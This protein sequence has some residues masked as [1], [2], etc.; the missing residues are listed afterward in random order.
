MISWFSGFWCFG[1][2]VYWFGLCLY[3]VFIAC[4]SFLVMFSMFVAC[5]VVVPCSVSYLPL[6]VLLSCSYR[7]FVVMFFSAVSRF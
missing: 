1:R 3:P 4:D 6:S 7:R 5:C 2:I